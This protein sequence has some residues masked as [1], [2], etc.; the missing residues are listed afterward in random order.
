MSWTDGEIDKLFQDRVKD[1]SFEYKG[2]YWKEFNASLSAHAPEMAAATAITDAEIDKLYQS[3]VAQLSFEYKKEYWES[4]DASSARY[5]PEAAAT[6][7]A[8]TAIDQ[9]Y[10]ANSDGLSFEYKDAYWSEM[11]AMLPQNRR[12][13]FL[14]FGTAAVFVGLLIATLF[15]GEPISSTTSR[16]LTENGATTDLSNG[17]ESSSNNSVS[18]TRESDQVVDGNEVDNSL[19]NG[20]ENKNPTQD[21][22]SSNAIPSSNSTGVILEPTGIVVSPTNPLLSQNTTSEPTTNEPT[23]VDSREPATP[24]LANVNDVNPPV[25]PVSEEEILIG[26]LPT[27]GLDREE[28]DKQIVNLQDQVNMPDFRMPTIPRF[29]VELNGGLSQSLISPSERLSSSVG[30]GLGFQFQ[31]GKFAFTT[32][33]NGIW[34]FHDDIVLNR[35]AKVYGFGSDVYQ[36]T[37]KYD[38]IYSLEAVLAMGYKFGV[39]QINVGVRP[40]YAFGSKVGFSLMEEDVEME[41]EVLYGHMEGIRRFGLK[42]MIGYSIDL[43]SNI[44]IGLNIGAQVMPSVNEEYID[45]QNNKLPID[46]QLYFRKSISFGR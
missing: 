5:V 40:S 43:P 6:S 10:Q 25:V 19:E 37:L 26:D 27:V 21:S 2:E 14:W 46:G 11:A 1:L 42:P 23:T 39:H 3:S 13:D 36:Y 31:K 22:G 38:H 9:L 8:D 32:G 30:V 4:F 7:M 35:Q 29:Y 18:E 24:N 17:N 41:R 15:I 44:T 28:M 12:P 33:V 20:A 45:G 34:S 16:L